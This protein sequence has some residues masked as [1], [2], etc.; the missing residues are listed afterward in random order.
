MGKTNSRSLSELSESNIPVGFVSIGEFVDRWVGLTLGTI[1]D[2]W[3]DPKF[4]KRGIGGELMD[5][6]LSKLKKS[7]NAF[8][9]L[10][11]S[12]SNKNALSLYKNKGFHET[13]IRMIK[14][15]G[16]YP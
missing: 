10:Q 5:Y 9:S 2:L 13:H 16:K 15:N 12:V 7:G 1:F 6:A 11:V 8:S 4:R 3:V 14:N